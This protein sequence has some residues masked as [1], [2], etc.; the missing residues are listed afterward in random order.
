M[1]LALP[2]FSAEITDTGTVTFIRIE[3]PYEMD[4]LPEISL[5]E[6]EEDGEGETDPQLMYVD[7]PFDGQA[8]ELEGAQHHFEYETARHSPV[9]VPPDEEDTASSPGNQAQEC[10]LVLHLLRK[11]KEGPGYW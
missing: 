4:L 5:L 2:F 10:I 6:H 8:E 7:G 1:A 9:L 11:F 3:D